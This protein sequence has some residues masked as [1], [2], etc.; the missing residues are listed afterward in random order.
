MKLTLNIVIERFI[1]SKVI[2]QNFKDD[3]IIQNYY[4][5]STA[6]VDLYSKGLNKIFNVPF[7][8]LIKYGNIPRG[9]ADVNL[10][11]EQI[12]AS[13]NIPQR[14][15]DEWANVCEYIP[16]SDT[17]KVKLK[18]KITGE[19]S[20]EMAFRYLLKGYNT[21]TEEYFIEEYNQ[22]LKKCTNLPEFIRNDLVIVSRYKTFFGKNGKRKGI[23]VDLYSKIDKKLLKNKNLSNLLYHGHLPS[24]LSYSGTCNQPSD[25][26]PGILYHIICKK[27]GIVCRKI[28]ITTRDNVYKRYQGDTTEVIEIINEKYLEKNLVKAERLLIEEFNLIFGK[29]IFGKEYYR[30]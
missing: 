27:N 17:P 26:T 1:Q 23:R 2:P 28:G 25:K 9:W 4:A 3:I 10:L 11:N 6:R 21:K 7:K 24:E 29:P 14:F 15:K 13:D 5:G 20:D 12:K 22:R 19:V 8:K 16:N 18:N 30:L